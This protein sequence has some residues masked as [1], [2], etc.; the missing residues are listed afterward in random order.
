MVDAVRAHYAER[1]YRTPRLESRVVPGTAPEVV[2]LTLDIDSGSRTR[3]GAV[4]VT[5]S[6]PISADAIAARLEA[7]AGAARTT[8]PRSTARVDRYEDDLRRLGHY[9]ATVESSVTF[10]EDNAARQPGH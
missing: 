10:S 9:E 2:T 4:S 7:R 6:P 5:G 8:P 3:V 1:G